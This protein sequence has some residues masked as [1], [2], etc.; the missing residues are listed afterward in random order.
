VGAYYELD[1]F[2]NVVCYF[3]RWFEHTEALKAKFPDLRPQLERSSFEGNHMLEVIKYYGPDYTALMLP[4]FNGGEIIAQAPNP[5]QQV[6]VFIAERPKWDVEIRGQFD[7]ALYVQ[8]ARARMSLHMLD[9]A[10]EAVNAPTI[11]PKDLLKLPMG[12]K[13]LWRTDTPQGAG[14]LKIEIPPQVFAENEKLLKEERIAARYP[15][16]R[17]G[18]I[19]A[20]VITGEG[21]KELLGTMSSQIRTAQDQFRVTF[22]DALAFALRMDE[23]YWPEVE[24]SAEGTYEGQD[25]S[26]R[27]RPSK[28]IKGQYDV[29]ATYG[30]M[31]GLDPNRALVALLQMRGDKLVSRAH[32]R[33]HLPDGMD[34]LELEAE[35]DIEDLTDAMKQSVF[36]M[37]AAI[38]QI[39]AQ[40]GNPAQ[41]GGQIARML[42]LRRSGKSFEQ[43]FLKALEPTEEEKAAAEQAAQQQAAQNP[44]G[45]ALGEA[46]AVTPGVSPGGNEGMGSVQ[47]LLAGLTSGGEP[48]LS[49]RVARTLPA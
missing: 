32:V 16:G 6:Q 1:L 18:N 40:G 48:V 13:A 26:E 31:S 12:P 24:K 33:R 20:S 17:T 47:Q 19:D 25:F 4:T 39:A 9:V 36:G 8:L 44:L 11:V 30:M 28:D 22:A 35:V 34:G 10:D 45:T 42:Q 41:I 7:Q 27:Y 49:G 2:G 14:K 21:I 23:E 38:P 46:G 43:A 15:E 37:A 5:M 3:K 29:K